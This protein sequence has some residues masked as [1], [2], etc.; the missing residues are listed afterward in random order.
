R[1]NAFFEDDA[2]RAEASWRRVLRPNTAVTQCQF[3]VLTDFVFNGGISASKFPTLV[4][5][6]RAGNLQDVPDLLLT[7][8]YTHNAQGR[9]PVVSKALVARREREATRFASACPC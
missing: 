1:V 3:D 5:L 2:G 8:I 7:V 6:L 9:P 4:R